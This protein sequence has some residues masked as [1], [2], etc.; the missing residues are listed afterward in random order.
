MSGVI[1]S[2]S[3]YMSS[4]HVQKLPPPRWVRPRSARWNACEW[5]FARPGSVTP[6]SGTASPRFA[7]GVTAAIRSPSMTINT[8]RLTDS[9]PSQANSA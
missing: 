7:P 4:R 2:A 5:A 3:A 6:R 9:P 1:R 8:S